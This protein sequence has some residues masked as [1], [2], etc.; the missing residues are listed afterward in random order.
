MLPL[1]V[2]IS[3]T[4]RWRT[5]VG[6]S[7]GPCHGS[8]SCTSLVASRS[9]DRPAAGCPAGCSWGPH[10]CGQPRRPGAGPTTRWFRHRSR[11]SRIEH[12]RDNFECN[13]RGTW[14]CRPHRTRARP[15]F[16]LRAGPTP[17]K[18]YRSRSFDCASK[19]VNH[20]RDTVSRGRRYD[21]PPT[22]RRRRIELTWSPLSGLNR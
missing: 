3:T 22:K 8:D 10:R 4:D 5:A 6:G 2:L 21:L 13:D 15:W 1:P 16:E 17:D 18:H 19:A 12:Q 14:R 9:S 11:N 7:G 20:S